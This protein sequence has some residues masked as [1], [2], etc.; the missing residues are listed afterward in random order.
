MWK[1]VNLAAISSALALSVPLT[2]IYN[3]S[4]VNRSWP[5]VWKVETVV[6]I[7][8]IPTPEDMNDIRP[9]SMTPLWSK[10]L[11]SFVASYTLLET[12]SNWRAN[13][14]G[15]RQGS[16]TD[17]VLIEVWDQIL[18]ELDAPSSR[19]AV[20]CGIDFSK[21]FSRCSYQLILKAYVELGASQWI[22]CL[23]YTS[24]SPRD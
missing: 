23:L 14:H 24:P 22:I 18:R 7:P 3:H 10:V 11:E 15:G 19:A 13:Q 21:S 9:I 16:C 6:P 17:H 20:I 12:R 8:K 1:V 5:D 4:F 2:L